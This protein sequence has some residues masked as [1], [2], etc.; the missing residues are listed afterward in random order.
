MDGSRIVAEGFCW[1]GEVEAHW[2]NIFP[3]KR[4]GSLLIWM[5]GSLLV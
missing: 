5:E 3:T 2:Q 4:E 1:W